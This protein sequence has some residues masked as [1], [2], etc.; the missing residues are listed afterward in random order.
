LVKD[1]A[2]SNKIP[3]SCGETNSAEDKT[4]EKAFN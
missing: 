1:K 3:A 4:F 2:S